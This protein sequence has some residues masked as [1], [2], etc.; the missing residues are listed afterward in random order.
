[1]KIWHIILIFAVLWLLSV[2]VW[3]LDVEHDPDAPIG[4]SDSSFTYSGITS[5]LNDD[6]EVEKLTL[7]IQSKEY[8]T[9]PVKQE[10][11]KK[12]KKEIDLI[13]ALACAEWGK[14]EYK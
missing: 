6:W 4:W 5:L 8:W 3:A 12:F 2:P 1:M 13:Q 11:L 10:C 14:I 7:Q 9:V